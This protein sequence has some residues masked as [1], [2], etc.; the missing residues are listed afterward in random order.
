[1]VCAYKYKQ[2]FRVRSPLCIA[3]SG[4]SEKYTWWLFESLAYIDFSKEVLFEESLA[5]YHY[6]NGYYRKDDI[7]NMFFDEYEK[8]I[9]KVKE[10]KQ[11]RDNAGRNG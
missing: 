9:K 6:L 10:I 5:I 7:E 11:D 3:G 2:F 1:M 4:D 8:V